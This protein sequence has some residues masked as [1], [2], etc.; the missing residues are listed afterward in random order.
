MRI[1]VATDR[2]G[3][4]GSAAAGEAIALGWRDAQPGA[5]IAVAPLGDSGTGFLDAVRLAADEAAVPADGR[6]LVD[7]LLGRPVR[8]LVDLGTADAEQHDAG[9]ALLSA[10]GA[11]IDRSGDT[12]SV[13][14][15]AARAL[16]GETELVG[17][18][19]DA[20]LDRHLLGLRGITAARGRERG[21]DPATMLAAD[22]AL[23]DFTRAVGRVPGAGDGAAGGTAYAITALGGRLVAAPAECARRV[24]L[25]PT[26]AAADLVI[27]GTTTFDFGSRGGGVVQHVADVA[28]AAL[29]PCIV[30]AGH[31]VIGGREMR[32]MGIE[33]AYGADQPGAPGLRELAA[34]VARTWTW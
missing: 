30:L 19:A 16:V 8:V 33:S 22:A 24:G 18:V 34:R 32:T 29:T 6:A 15:A 7:A 2:Q 27:T 25:A 1:L 20:D 11:R 13:D 4:L 9:A 3:D 14:L 17:V 5:E 12:V 26:A 23:E 10:L 28:Q 31:V 21:D